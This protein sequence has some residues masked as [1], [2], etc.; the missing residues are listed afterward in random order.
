MFVD[1]WFYFK[2]S[3]DLAD[4]KFKKTVSN[5]LIWFDT[6]VID[7]NM[8]YSMYILIILLKSLVRDEL[9]WLT[10]YYWCWFKTNAMILLM[11]IISNFIKDL[12]YTFGWEKTNQSKS[13]SDASF[14]AC[15]DVSSNQNCL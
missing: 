10:V 6:I 9:I 13:D 2:I 14:P 3:S 8:L 12:L 7:T 15:L 1:L 11:I 5:E 4:K